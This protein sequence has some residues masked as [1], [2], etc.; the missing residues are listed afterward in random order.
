MMNDPSDTMV[1]ITGHWLPYYRT[2]GVTSHRTQRKLWNTTFIE[3]E[4]PSCGRLNKRESTEEYN[5]TF[6]MFIVCILRFHTAPVAQH[7]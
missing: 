7:P 3:R 1:P 5:K 6:I 4:N 2:L